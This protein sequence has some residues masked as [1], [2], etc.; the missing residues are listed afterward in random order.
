VVAGS[1]RRGYSVSPRVVVIVAL[2]PVGEILYTPGSTQIDIFEYWGDDTE[3]EPIIVL[4]AAGIVANGRP[5]MY[6]VESLPY[7]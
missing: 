5:P 1:W 3:P 2:V 6:A 4:I 7:T